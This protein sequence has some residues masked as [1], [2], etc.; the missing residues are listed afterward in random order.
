[1]DACIQLIT[2]QTDEWIDVDEDHEYDH[3]SDGT[4]EGIIPSKVI[5][6]IRETPGAENAEYRTQ[7]RARGYQFPSFGHCGP[8]FIYKGEGVEDQSQ[9]ED[10][11]D[12]V[13]EIFKGQVLDA[14]PIHH[15]PL[16]D[17]QDQ[18]AEQQA[19]DDD[20]EFD[21]ELEGDEDIASLE[22]MNEAMKSKNKG[23]LH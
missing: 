15:R 14:E 16:H 20:D 12:I 7:D 22:D 13:Q 4:V 21:E 18:A 11:P 6:E 19:H 23:T 17:Q 10:P 5:D 3:R 1:M 2:D 8:V 9:H